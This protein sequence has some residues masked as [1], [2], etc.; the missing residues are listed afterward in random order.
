MKR[1]KEESRMREAMEREEEM[2]K[3][4]ALRKEQREELEREK[5]V[6][7]NNSEQSTRRI[8]VAPIE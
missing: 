2:R 8:K 5:I 1:R 7:Q 4:I 6:N 3:R